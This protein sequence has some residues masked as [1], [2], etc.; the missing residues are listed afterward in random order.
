MKTY[1]LVLLVSC[2]FSSTSFGASKQAWILKTT[3]SNTSYG[4]LPGD[5]RKPLVIIFTTDIESSLNGDFTPIGLL[6][7]QK[8][9]PVA[10]IDV[11]CHGNDV[12]TKEVAGLDCWAKRIKNVNSDI[13]IDM[14]KRSYDMIADVHTHKQAETSSIFVIGV[15]RGGYA[16]LKLAQFNQAA[17]HLIL[18]SPVTNLSKLSEFKNVEVNKNLYSLEASYKNLANDHIFLQIGTTDD[19][20]GTNEALNFVNGVVA[21]GKGKTVDLTAILTPNRG[22]GSAMPEV[23]FQWALDQS[24]KQ[25]KNAMRAP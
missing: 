9:Y 22:H 7:S 17:D 8:G 1:F 3:N 24:L 12:R 19:R 6:L 11:T 5:V 15:S 4:F 14:V 21:T 18:I 25:K 13:F 23:A 16:A 2:F 10:S 20:V